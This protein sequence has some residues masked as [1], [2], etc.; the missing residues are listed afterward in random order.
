MRAARGPFTGVLVI[1]V[2]TSWF[3]LA[4]RGGG[5]TDGVAVQDG[6]D[7]TVLLTTSVPPTTTEDTSPEVGMTTVPVVTTPQQPDK[8]PVPAGGLK[9][10]W[11]DWIT[12]SDEQSGPR[13][14]SATLTITTGELRDLLVWVASQD[15]VVTGDSMTDNQ[16]EL[17]AGGGYSGVLN[18]LSSS[19]FSIEL[20]R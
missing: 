12:T 16:W 8:L 5:S 20:Q 19:S 17:A 6:P 7:T 18:V 11:P 4:P 13:S 3:M 15:W 9:P 1:A 10:K 2:A 14:Y